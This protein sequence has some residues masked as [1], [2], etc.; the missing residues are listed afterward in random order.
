[1]KKIEDI[2]ANNKIMITRQGDDGCLGYLLING[3]RFSFV[4]SWGEGWEHLSVSQPNRTPTW[5]EMCVAKDMF[6]RKD[7]CCVEYHPSESDYV[8]IHEHCLHIWKPIAAN[9]PTPPTIFV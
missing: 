8:N 1:M 7:E 9:L 3:Q 6:W 5:D 4:F 2:K